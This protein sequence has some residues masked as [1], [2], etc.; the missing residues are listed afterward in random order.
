ME[1][2]KE[3]EEEFKLIRAAAVKPKSSDSQKLTF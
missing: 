3:E 2:E 1:E